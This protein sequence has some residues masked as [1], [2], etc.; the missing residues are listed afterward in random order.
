MTAADRALIVELL[1]EMRALRTEIAA[2]RPR[3]N[4]AD[5]PVDLLA[6]IA[7]SV[8]DIPFTARELVAHTTAVTNLRRAL[9]AVDATN[10]RKVGNCWSAWKGAP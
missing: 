7:D 1:A 2:M 10:P 6:V 3:R 9:A 5:V 8:R 4:V